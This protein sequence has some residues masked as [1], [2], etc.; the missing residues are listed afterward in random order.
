MFRFLLGFWQICD[1][2]F[3]TKFV[4]KG[5]LSWITSLLQS[6]EDMEVAEEP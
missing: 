1:I 5:V 2:I 3:V 6:P 4:T